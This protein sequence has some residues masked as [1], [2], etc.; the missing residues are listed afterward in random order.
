MKKQLFSIILFSLFI[1]IIGFTGCDTATTGP[2]NQDNPEQNK[3]LTDIYVAHKPYNVLYE[4]GDTL[5]LSG[6]VIKAKYSD[7][8]EDVVDGWA[9]SPED[10]STLTVVGDSILIT[11]TYKDKSVSFTIRVDEKDNNAVFSDSFFWGTWVR[12]DNGTEYE[13]LDSYVS[14]N[15]T[16]YRILD[17]DSSSLTV[18]TLG[19]FTK[20]SEEVKDVIKNNSIPYFRKGGTNLEYSLKIVGFANQNAG[21]AAATSVSGIKGIGKST[22]YKN[23]HSDGESN[24]KGE[25]VLTAPTINDEQTVTITNGNEVV[26]VS[27]LKIA[28]SGDYMGTIAL[29]N[30]NQYNLKVT[31]IIEEEYKDDGY[32]FGNYTKTYV[33]SIYFENISENECTSSKYEIT[34]ADSNLTIEP[35]DNS[36]SNRLS[37]IIPKILPDAKYGPIKVKLTYGDITKPFV[38]TG[39]NIRI[40]NP[41]LNGDSSKDQE[42]VDYIPLRFFRGLIPITISAK[43]VMENNSALNGFIIFPDGNSRFFSVP[44]DESM[45]LLVPTF[46]LN[47]QYLLAFSGATVSKEL[48][49]SSV[50]LYTVSPGTSAV[51]QVDT[52]D[53][54]L[55]SYMTNGGNNHSEEKAV[56]VE[57]AFE[58]YLSDGEVDYWSVKAESN[59]IFTPGKTKYCTVSFSSEYQ[60]EES[61]PSS[62]F[63]QEGNYIREQQISPVSSKGM[64]FLGWF[65][66]KND[67]E[68]VEG[69]CI[70]SDTELYAKWEIIN[71]KIDY[72]LN[73]GSFSDVNVA[74][75]SYTIKDSF[76][77]T[78][79]VRNG[80]KFLGWFTD[81]A[82]KENK[83][84]S[85]TAGEIGDKKF[86]A[87]WEIITYSVTYVLNGGT[88]NSLNKESYTVED[89]VW[90]TEPEKT[91]YE[92]AGWY[93]TEDFTD[94]RLWWY[95]SGTTGNKIVYAKWEIAHYPVTYEL[96]GGTNDSENPASYTMLNAA[97]TLKNPSRKGCTFSGWYKTVNDNETAVTKI[98]GGETGAI[99]L[100]AKWELAE[101]SITY[102][103]N[104]GTN[105]ASNPAN[106]T[107]ESSTITFAEPS[108]TGYDFKG[109]YETSNYT[110]D[111]ITA[112]PAESTG[113]RTLYAKWQLTAYSITYVLNGGENGN[114][115]ATYTMADDAITLN[116]PSK[117]GYNFLGWYRT[118]SFIGTEVTAIA[119]G[120]TGAI[121]LYAK[122]ELAE[123][124]IT[125]ELNGGT[126]NTANPAVY[127]IESSTI[128]FAEPSRTGYDFM[129][130]YGA[131]DYSGDAITAIPAESTGN[132]TLYTKWQIVTY[133]I[134]YTLNGGT[135]SANNPVSYNVASNQISLAAANK[136]GYDF[137]GWFTTSSFT[138]D[139]VDAVGG[140][141]TGNKHFYAKYQPKEYSINYVLNGGTNSNSNP[142]GYTIESSTITF[143]EPARTGYGFIGW[144]ATSDFS[145][146][147]VTSI[148]AGSTGVVTLYAKWKNTGFTV[149]VA[150][151]SDISVTKTES[152]T[153]LTFTASEDY[154]NYQ[155][156]IDNVA[157]TVTGNTLE[158]ETSSL[159]A[160][161][162]SI[163]LEASKNGRYY[164]STINV[165]VGGN[166]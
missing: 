118:G 104:G 64:T 150:P 8:T 163:Y 72:E 134:E 96:D 99:T 146:P 9:S 161:V 23:F 36:T 67:I 131:S 94:S 108:R 138:G 147:K 84:T 15:G 137:M 155:W 144:Y 143:A 90:L 3:K 50:M 44:D 70:Y 154:S 157:Q 106:Y 40:I 145:G 73:S 126:N 77:L 71:Y 13:V 162:Y 117:K 113:N 33:M 61:L 139:A 92:F 133:S 75:T 100:Y 102:E 141:E 149:T 164:S 11:I 158:F 81:E 83:V 54:M 2:Q 20:E 114:N 28:N 52:D 14:E 132:R 7:N 166:N 142:A 47:E 5:N 32:L 19:T 6:L 31:G 125:Y 66:K 10:G 68:V 121:T 57:E 116:V 115:P 153:T 122:W 63:I 109:W 165:T 127:T 128:T 156:Y 136:N 43:S 159:T 24:E 16:P 27:G 123:Y 18:E 29:V 65:D 110:G 89:N 135:N 59:E 49:K 25:I 76:E 51:K 95:L 107:I 78:E 93:E 91:G 130:W 37:Y 53:D 55:L 1:I 74:K 56:E 82:C 21:R 46:G 34:S 22:K 79:P 60:T 97:I 62:F 101:Y 151:Y 160:G 30:K 48:S 124:S 129:G 35:Y 69:T 87:K 86:Y 140:G 4:A 85:V 120:E 98:A 119:G 38:D 45:V 152:G 41:D 105:S 12:M 42:W 103:L 148:P 26:V 112:I 111:A 80:C 39:V 58:A 17:A 88:N